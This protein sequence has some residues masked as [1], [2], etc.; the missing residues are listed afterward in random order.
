VF[1][2]LLRAALY[3]CFLLPEAP[4]EELGHPVVLSNIGKELPGPE[5]AQRRLCRLS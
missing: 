2:V 5:F 4:Q 1:S 3:Q